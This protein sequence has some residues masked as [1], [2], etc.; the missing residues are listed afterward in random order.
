MAV[1]PF[2]CFLYF[3]AS[4]TVRRRELWRSCN[5]KGQVLIENNIRTSL[6]SRSNCLSFIRALICHNLCRDLS[7]I[8]H[9]IVICNYGCAASLLH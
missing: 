6:S 4:C 8:T 5:P 3:L 1:Y 2:C 9:P 7:I